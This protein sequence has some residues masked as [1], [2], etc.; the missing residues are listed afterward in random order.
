[1]SHDPVVEDNVFAGNTATEGGG[2][3]FC[4][5]YGPIAEPPV[6]RNAF[7]DNEALGKFGKGGGVAI[8]DADPVITNCTFDGNSAGS[9]GGGLYA[10]QCASA[11]VLANTIVTNSE[12]GG[13]V[14]VENGL[15][16]TSLCDVW[17]NAGGDYVN[18]SPAPDDMSADP[19][20]C[21]PATRDLTLQDDSPC[22]PENNPWSALI[23]AYGAGGCGT[24]VDSELAGEDLFQLNAPFPNPARGPV[25]LSY[26]LAD[27][28]A[29]VDIL[30]LSV[31]GRVVRR[32]GAAPGTAG[33]HRLIWDGTGE[34]GWPVA[35]GVYLVRGRAAGQS[36]HR[37]LVVLGHR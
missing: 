12:S 15:L 32:L 14:A 35:S 21:S 20:F 19:L 2:A 24:S 4:F 6:R 25:T 34:D 27:P 22:L 5:F 13:G 11:P 26:E 29:S 17:N 1:M 3:R 16:V 8:Y 30:I 23:G 18:C 7:F 31:D 9:I 33:E 10:N 37:G 28:A 36:C